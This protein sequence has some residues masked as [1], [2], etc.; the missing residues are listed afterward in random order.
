MFF[1]DKYNRIFIFCIL[2]IILLFLILIYTAYVTFQTQNFFVGLII[3]IIVIFLIFPIYLKIIKS[4]FT[5][6]IRFAENYVSSPITE[7]HH[8]IIFMR[9]QDKMKQDFTGDCINLLGVGL[10]QNGERFKI[11][12]CSE[13]NDFIRRYID[14]NV[15]HLWIIGHGRKN[16][17]N[18]DNGEKIFYSDLP[19]VDPKEFIAQLHCSNGEGDPLPIINRAKSQF[20][21]NYKRLSHQNRCYILSKMKNYSIS[22]RW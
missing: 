7:P 14:P 2:L 8:G 3:I 11:Y 22:K 5:E 15:T 9:Y 12:E 10:Q 16:R 4:G 6:S 19:I 1:C 21:S 18:F 13:P 20:Y 17:L